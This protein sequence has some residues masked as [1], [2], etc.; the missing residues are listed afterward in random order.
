M[1]SPGELAALLARQWQRSAWREQHLLNSPERWPLRLPIGLPDAPTFRD[2][3]LALRQHLQQWLAI[4]KDGRGHGPGS[5]EW[6]PRSYRGGAAPV[7]VPKTWVLPRPSDLIAAIGLFA[8]HG[9]ADITADYQAL[10]SVLAEVD[11]RFHRLLMRRLALWRHLPPAQA[12]AIAQVALQLT[13]GCAAGKPLRA[14]ALG[15]NDSKFFERHEGLLKAMLD[16]LFDGEAGR[17]GLT[18]FLDASPEGEHWLLV[19][20]MAEGL[21]PFRRLRVTT[22]ELHQRA[23]PSHRI[24]LVENERCLHQLPNPLPGTIAILGAGLNLGWLSA[25]WL[26]GRN[27]AYWGDLDTWGLVMLGTARNHLPHL[28][29]L[30]MDRATF[31]MH[32]HLAVT[33]PVHAT[34]VASTLLQPNETALHQHLIT[35]KKGRLEQEFLPATAVTQAIEDWK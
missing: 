28:R 34:N 21:L 29:A 26:R 10:V 19:A 11:V 23:L 7:E 24:L 33:E 30:L 1:K 20:P 35:L 9:H 12:I 31:D 8:A 13:P 4:S 3:G 2:A 14:L 25:S 22:S 27:V 32:Q 15:G 18:A 17:Q 16:E 5:V 6:E